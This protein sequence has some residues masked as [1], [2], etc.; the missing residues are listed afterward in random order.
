MVD[1]LSTHAVLSPSNMRCKCVGMGLLRQ[2]LGPAGIVAGVVGG[3]CLTTIAVTILIICRK[4][5][6]TVLAVYKGSP[7]RDS[8]QGYDDGSYGTGGSLRRH[9]AVAS[10][11]VDADG[12]NSC[13]P[14]ASCK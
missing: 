3:V 1:L 7:E 13:S 14:K 9:S 6:K 4:R 5:R 8:Q 12:M 2:G 10:D 11:I